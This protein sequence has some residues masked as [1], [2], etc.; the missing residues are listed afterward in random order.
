MIIGVQNKSTLVSEP[1]TYAMTLACDWQARHH[2]G[3]AWATW[4][5]QVIYLKPGQNAADLPAGTNVITLFDN[6]D[7]AGALGY[8]S[9]NAGGIV[10]G[11]VFAEPVLQNGGNALT[12]ELS[13]ASVLSHEVLETLNDPACNRWCDTGNGDAI[14]LEVGD[15][16]ESDSY[17][18]TIGTSTVTVSNFVMPPWF[19]P[20]AASDAQFDWLKL[21]SQPFEVRQTGYV[22]VLSE[23]TVSQKFGEQYPEW[24]K[25]MKDSP[26]ARTHR[27]L[28]QGHHRKH[29]L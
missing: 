14:A 6:S 16:V 1:D 22:L 17:P 26:L 8:H 18:L 2:A 25:A 24:R 11:R 23:G 12:K 10:Y 27:R 15:P 28:G 20:D 21:T 4:P 29:F 7:Q 5:P 9:E 13:V 19:D 3:P